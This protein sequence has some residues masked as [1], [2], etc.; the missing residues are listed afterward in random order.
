MAKIICFKTRQLLADLETEVTPR[1]SYIDGNSIQP[2]PI[3]VYQ[4]LHSSG[5]SWLEYEE[6]L[7]SLIA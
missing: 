1:R 5:V 3:E 6:Y 2:D 7:S 4:A